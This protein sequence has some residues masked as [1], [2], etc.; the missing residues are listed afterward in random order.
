[1]LS[2]VYTEPEWHLISGVQTDEDIDWFNKLC[3]SGNTLSSA[4]TLST[5]VSQNFTTAEN[6]T[7]ETLADWLVVALETANADPRNTGPTFCLDAFRIKGGVGK[8]IDAKLAVFKA[9][10]VVTSAALP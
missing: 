8:K 2:N 5:G 7:P 3:A 10:P 9:A 4:V 1:M 6:I